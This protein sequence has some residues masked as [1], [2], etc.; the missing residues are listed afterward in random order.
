MNPYKNFRD[1]PE[2]MTW[3]EWAEEQDM[4]LEEREERRRYFEEERR[5]HRDIDKD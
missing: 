3:E 4:Y 1:K 5:D 2:D